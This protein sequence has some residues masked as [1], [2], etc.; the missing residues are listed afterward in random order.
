M[1]YLVTI[2]YETEQLDRNGDARLQKL[3]YVFE[4]ESTEEA[5]L[6]AN[7][8][9]GED[10]RASRTLGINE[11]PIECIISPTTMPQYYKTK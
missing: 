6:L 3:K 9:R 1:Y 11:H 2:G 7:K 5:L 10:S 8:Y 4:A